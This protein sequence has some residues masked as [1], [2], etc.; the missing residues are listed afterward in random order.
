MN[1]VKGDKVAMIKGL[2]SLS[3]VGEVFEVA[4]ITD[5][6]VVLRDIPSGI[7]L[8]TVNIDDFDSHFKKKS[9]LVN[10]TDWHYILDTSGN[11]MAYYRAN[12]RTG[13]VNVKTPDGFRSSASCSQ[14][15][16]FN[17]AF[18]IKLAMLRCNRKAIKNAIAHYED[19]VEL[20]E[21]Q[22][23]ENKDAINKLIKTSNAKSK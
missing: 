4:N 9:E 6:S 10:W 8:C 13:K 15:D 7:I 11:I 21:S 20:L 1:I 5:T 16:D 18:G 23:V 19:N 3:L 2:E 14:G 12:H 17:L 22:L